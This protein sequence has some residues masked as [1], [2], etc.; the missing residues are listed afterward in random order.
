MSTKVDLAAALSQIERVRFEFP[1]L[2]VIATSSSKAPGVDY[3]AMRAGAQ[4][5]WPNR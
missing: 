2:S 1:N 5:F 3:R 4:S